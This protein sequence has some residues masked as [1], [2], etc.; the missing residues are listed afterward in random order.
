M[1]LGI[2]V[3]GVALLP[4]YIRAYTISGDSDAPAYVSGDRVVVNLAAYD[5]RIP[6]SNRVLTAFGDPR[7]G[8]M[9]LFRE[10]DGQL[11]LKRVVAGSGVDVAMQNNHLV[12]DGRPLEYLPVSDQERFRN[13]RGMLGTSLE[14]EQADERQVY[15]SYTPGLGAHG[16]FE[17]VQ[18]P[19]DMYFLLGSNRDI[20]ADSRTYGLIHRSQILG[21]VVGRARTAG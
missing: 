20:S 12:L 13:S 15:V 10:H 6:Y 5:F 11:A 18:V 1:T 21:K 17:P 14:I 16:S 9:V 2:A 8:D 3:V 7:P 4:G 19:K